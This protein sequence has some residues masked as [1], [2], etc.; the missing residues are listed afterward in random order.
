MAVFDQFELRVDPNHY[1]YW[2]NGGGY[3]PIELW[4]NGDSLLELVR[5]IEK[6]FVEQEFKQRVD[7][8]EFPDDCRIQAGNYGFLPASLTY[9]PCRNLLDQPFALG[10]DVD[11]INKQKSIV[12]GCSCS[13]IECWPLLVKVELQANTVVWKAF[14]QLHRDWIYDLGPFIFDRQLYEDELNS[15]KK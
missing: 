2:P 11:E 6:P 13:V 12:L 4:I 10:I 1:I 15:L 5:E 14:S 3:Q 7:Q 8:G 9:S